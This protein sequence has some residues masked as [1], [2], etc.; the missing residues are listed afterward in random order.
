MK[1]KK[2]Y[3]AK[4]TKDPEVGNDGSEMLD[5][6]GTPIWPYQEAT[7]NDIASAVASF[8]TMEADSDVN[9]DQAAY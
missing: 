5:S 8:E 4:A 6:D 7:V 3:A 2:S 9:H 1:I